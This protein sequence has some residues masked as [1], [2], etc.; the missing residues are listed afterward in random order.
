MKIIFLQGESERSNDL[1]NKFICSTKNDVVINTRIRISNPEND[2]KMEMDCGGCGKRIQERMVLCVGDRTWHAKCLK[3][4]VCSRSLHDQ[5]SC[6][7]RNTRVY[8]RQDYI[9]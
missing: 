1:P 2:N 8:C 3:C 5:N 4:Y 7:L 6:F 9:M